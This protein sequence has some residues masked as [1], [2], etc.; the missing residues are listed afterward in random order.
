MRRTG[1]PST[2]TPKTR[3]QHNTILEPW[4][5]NNHYLPQIIQWIIPTIEHCVNSWLVYRRSTADLTWWQTTHVMYTVC[6]WDNLS[7]LLL[8]AARVATLLLVLSAG[9]RSREVN[10]VV[11]NHFGVIITANKT[12]SLTHSHSLTTNKRV[13]TSDKMA[14][15]HSSYLFCRL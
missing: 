2:V 3:P 12:F 10:S 11:A 8:L 6:V 14:F 9:G 13:I 1:K 7:S 15:F 5:S 4:I